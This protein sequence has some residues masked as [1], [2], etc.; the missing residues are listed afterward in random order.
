MATWR[1]VWIHRRILGK[2]FDTIL[3][4]PILQ[5]FKSDKSVQ[6]SFSIEES[7]GGRVRHLGSD[8]DR[9]A[10]RN[11][12]KTKRICFFH[13]LKIHERIAI[14]LLEKMGSAFHLYARVSKQKDASTLQNQNR[15]NLLSREYIWLNMGAIVFWVWVNCQ[16]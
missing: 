10:K 15:F 9:G 4:K 13:G 1:K 2:G 16:Y 3:Q 8:V 11:I 5:I 6:P 14:P 12:T 7:D